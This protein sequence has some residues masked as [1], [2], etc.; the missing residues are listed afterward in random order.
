[1]NTEMYNHPLTE[2][3][4]NRLRSWG[5]HVIEPVEKMLACGDKGKG[6]LPPVDDVVAYIKQLLCAPLLATNTP[7]LLLALLRTRQEHGFANGVHKETLHITPASRFYGSVELLHPGADAGE[8]LS[9]HLANHGRHQ[10]TQTAGNC[11]VGH[12]EIVASEVGSLLQTE[13]QSTKQAH[14]VGARLLFGLNGLQQERKAHHGVHLLTRQKTRSQPHKDG[15]RNFQL[16]VAEGHP[17]LHEYA[18]EIAPRP[19]AS[20]SQ[21]PAF[22][23]AGIPST[24][25]FPLRME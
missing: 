15:E 25:P 3:Q 7:V 1:M 5:V 20:S 8:V 24:T 22:R 17:L 11:D 9:L 13:L 18:G 4:L 10:G 6:A 2:E 23:K 14:D 12:R 16:I 19:R 21:A